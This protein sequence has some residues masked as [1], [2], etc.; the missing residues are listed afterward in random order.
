MDGQLLTG[1]VLIIVGIALGLLAY[2]IILSR[3]ER[4][5]LDAQ[6]TDSADAP[7]P[8]GPPDPAAPLPGSS[9]PTPLPLSGVPPAGG[10]VPLAEL[11]R[12]QRTGALI[13][14]LGGKE[15][16]SASE[17]RASA[18][19]TVLESAAGELRRWLAETAEADRPR[20]SSRKQGL[21]KPHTMID[22]INEILTRKLDAAG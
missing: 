18:G 8:A 2:A 9:G 15:Y 3:K 4:A 7:E 11:L 1:L 21:P 16:R 5:A 13:V 12:D 20:Q 19:W 6:S 22:Q 10:T 14:R 17:L